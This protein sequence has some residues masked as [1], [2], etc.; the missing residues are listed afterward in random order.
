VSTNGTPELRDA[1]E[2]LAPGTMLRDAVERIIGAGRGA[3]VVLAWND[4]VA[5]TITG[6]FR[7]DAKATSQR[8]AELAK[9]DGALIVDLD[10][11]HIHHANVHLVPDA[12]IPTSETGTRHRTAERIAR[13]TG[14]PV[15]SV[16]ESMSR[17]TLYF[18]DRKHVLEEV[19]S[20]L[21]RANQALATLER[22][23][24]RLTEV[25]T[26]LADRELVGEVTLRD[27][28]TALQRSEMVRRIEAEVADLVGE[29][30]RE[31][32]L[33]ELQR[34]ELMSGVEE[35]RRLLV[36][37]YR[38]DRRK[39]L[40]TLLESLA[41]LTSREL[42]DLGK[43]AEVLGLEDEGAVEM[44]L[45]PRGYRLLS[46]IPRLPDPVSEK[47]VQRFGSM[48]RILTATH[49]ELQAVDGVGEARASSILEG[50]RRLLDTSRVEM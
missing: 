27:V 11:E 43:I 30:G 31:G 28:A 16:S 23:R 42:L 3:L 13:Q 40:E 35:T 1:L 4:E 45:E 49:E 6:G 37:D 9:M 38:S 34:A 36:E 50:L 33:I 5:R 20:L 48:R 32:R 7:M 10:A 41:S 17:V 2:E 8:L 26:R 44:P 14:A 29:L 18:G 24:T 15:I 25:T 47:V 22:Y 12:S 39:R 46:R 19:S 21:F